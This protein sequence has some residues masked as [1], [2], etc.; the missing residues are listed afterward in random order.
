MGLQCIPSHL[1]M[2]VCSSSSR[3]L[4]LRCMD[5]YKPLFQKHAMMQQSSPHQVC[6]QLVLHPAACVCAFWYV[7][8]DSTNVHSTRRRSCAQLTLSVCKSAG[9]AKPRQACTSGW[10]HPASDTPLPGEYEASTPP[11]PQTS[12]QSPLPTPKHQAPGQDNVSPLVQRCNLLV[13]IL[14]SI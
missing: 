6:K 4:N 12:A 1:F 5:W 9:S 13:H 8:M 14:L 3:L 2:H 10:R 11:A 7:R